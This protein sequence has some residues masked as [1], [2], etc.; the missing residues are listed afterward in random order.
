MSYPY[1][2]LARL[3]ALARAEGTPSTHGLT[4]WIRE[5]LARGVLLSDSRLRVRRD[6]EL[7]PVQIYRLNRTHPVVD[8]A[9][10]DS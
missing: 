5:A 10:R 3:R 2:S 8:E 4:R 6:G 7:E 9:L 1:V